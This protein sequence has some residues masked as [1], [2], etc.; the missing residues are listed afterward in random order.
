MRY[1]VFCDE[2][3]L[4]DSA[5]DTYKIIN[6]K[7]DL[8]LNKAGS[9]DF[10]IYPNHPNFER[11][12]KLKSIVTVYQ[13][14]YMIF[15]GRILND[16]QKFYDEKQVSCEGELAFLVDSVQRPYSFTG[17]PTD[18]FTQLINNHNS[19][20][21]EDKKFIVGEVTV[22]DKNDYINRSSTEYPNTL[23]E[24]NN[25]LVKTLGGY[26]NIRHESDG[27]YIDWIADFD[28]LSNQTIEFGKNLIDLN[29]ITKGEDV[30]TA[31]IPLGAKIEGE[32]EKRLTIANVNNG[33][34]YVY[35]EDAVNVYGWIFKTQTWDDVTI[36]SNLLRKAKEYLAEAKNLIGSIELNAVDA[37]EIGQNPFRLGTYV[38]VISKPHNLNTKFLV[39]KLQLELTSPAS[40]KL[41]LGTTYSTFTEQSTNEFKTQGEIIT[42]ITG[43]VQQTVQNAIIELEEKTSS[44]IEQSSDEIVSI[45]KE[46]VYSKSETDKLIE[47]TNTQI[48]QN[49]SE[50]EIKFNQL[51]TNVEDVSSD[52]NARFNEINKYIRFIDGNIVLGE[53]GNEITLRIEN[54]RISF[55]QSNSEVAYFTNNK[56]YV[57]D[58]EYSNSLKIG[59]FAF[60]PRSNGNLSI[61][62]VG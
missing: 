22:T 19:Q 40:N 33:V 35:D 15:R 51:I 14:D 11:L 53:A 4:F 41:T 32:T 28:I 49:S 23:D 5:M 12:R 39:S 56:L 3:L 26:L 46:D 37:P 34:D 18:L 50:I 59:K 29:R 61:R 30:A 45:V 57:T 31:I 20:V 16:E 52:T 44:M 38:N 27:N 21:S 8:E 58:G 7:L 55:L 54:D 6:P 10:T 13:N 17:S 43:S 1:K 62:K 48:T 2:Y 25:K 42:N 60:V 9:F 47:S 36:D 24:L